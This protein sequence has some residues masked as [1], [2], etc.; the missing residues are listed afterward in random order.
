[1]AVLM[2]IL[3]GI[4][5]NTLNPDVIKLAIYQ[6]KDICRRLGIDE[7]VFEDTVKRYQQFAADVKAHHPLG[8]MF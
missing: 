1:M 6:A 3:I 2:A 8:G 7:A 5:G 4:T